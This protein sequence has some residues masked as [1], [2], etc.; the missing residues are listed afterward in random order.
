MA[1]KTVIITGG[2][3]GIG[4]DITKA[5]VD[6]GYTVIVGARKKTDSIQKL[7]PKPIFVEIDVRNESDHFK[8]VEKAIEITGR[9]DVYINNAGYSEWRPI[10]EI[11]QDFLN[12][13]INTN[14][15]GA[16][17]GVKA[18]LS[19][20]KSGSSIIN[21]SSIASKRGSP[22][23]SA[24]VATKFA[25]NGM[26]Q[27]I[28]KE[29]GDRGIR[30]NGICPVLISTKGL[31]K[32]LESEHSPANGDPEG[33]ISNFG[34]ANAALKRLPSGS[35]VGSMCL[36]LASDDSSAITAQNINVDCGVFP[37]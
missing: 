15:V 28:A 27:S 19:V 26:T 13:I 22:N 21:I 6:D 16:F 4:F 3:R 30:I 18:A 20:M 37:Q 35:E 8:L 9:L 23:N 17:W 12:D 11:D 7:I 33:F 24:Y 34:L 31:I 1:K 2:N 14:L 29:V 32:A 25:M 36:F 10:E 5:F